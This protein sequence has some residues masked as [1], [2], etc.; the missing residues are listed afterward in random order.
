MASKKDYYEVLGLDKGAS[1]SEIKKAYRSL[2]KKYHPDANPDNKEAEAKFK[3]VGEAYEVLSDSQKRAAYDQFGHAAFEQGGG[4]GAGG[5]SGNMGGMGDIF[6]NIFGGGFG[7]IFGGGSR[8]RNGPR[9]GEDLQATVIISF[10]EAVFGCQKEINIAVTEQCDE[11]KG[12]GA[13]P[14][15][16][17]ETCKNCNGSGQERVVQQTMFGAM[18]SVR[19]CS[20]CGGSGKVIKT[21]CSKCSGN[22]NV[23]VKRSVKF[24]VPKGINHGQSIRKSGMGNAGERGGGNGDLYIEINVRPHKSFVRKENNIYLDV[25]I[26]FAQAAL[27]D[28]ITIPTID[29]DEEYTLKAGTQPNSTD[30]LK[31]KGVFNVRNPKVRG[32]QIITF[33]V[34][35]PTKLSEKQKKILREF[36]EECGEKAPKKG[37]WNKLMED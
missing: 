13:K 17:P 21:P 15:T 32:D 33:K 24:D 18:Q 2:A 35:V 14:G 31:N 28:T 16:Y 3:E 6:E 19:T 8:R 4:G 30:T 12:T 37:F 5:F 10:E 25:P 29:G 20:H 11:C 9:R 7:D 27:G 36:A 1:D 23:K 34:Q 26:T 22:G